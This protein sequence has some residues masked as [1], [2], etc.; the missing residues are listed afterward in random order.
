[1]DI[2]KDYYR[3]LGVLEDAEDIV[4]KAAYR[5]L[6]QKFHPDKFQGAAKIAEERMKEINE[7]YAVLSDTTSRKKYDAQRGEAEYEDD[8]SEDT[9]D[10]L[11]TLDKDWADAL[12][13]YP[14]LNR[15]ALS[16]T[17]YSKKLEYTFKTI[18]IE[19]KEFKN[20]HSLADK[21]RKDYLEKYFG[22]NKLIQEFAT[23][24]FNT[25]RL[26]ILKKLNRAVN[27]LGANIEA[28]RV[29]E[30]INQ[31]Y[32]GSEAEP[33]KSSEFFAQKLQESIKLDS[34]MHFESHSFMTVNSAKV[35]LQSIGIKVEA[36]GFFKSLSGGKDYFIKSF[37][38]N[39]ELSQ[40]EMVEFAVKKSQESSW[41]E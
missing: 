1:M 6:A 20:R 40:N 37:K 29:I 27:L 16:L 39:M 17:K 41:R 5:A 14:D 22:T 12:E 25:N 30:K 34:T 36:T 31:E 28:E 3:I 18:L 35:F 15:I 19:R 13:Y 32:F 21:L 11:H 33:E 9:D 4:I 26:D 38:Y 24:L 8:A 10:L 7:A 2:N 23:E